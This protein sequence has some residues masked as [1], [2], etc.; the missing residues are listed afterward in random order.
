M[1]NYSKG[2]FLSSIP[3]VTRN[4]LILNVL[5]WGVIELCMFGNDSMQSFSSFLTENL[6][7]HF[8]GS[9]EFQP[10][11]LVTYMFVHDPGS[12][13]HLLFNMFTLWM[14]GR[15]ME[16][17]WGSKRFALFYFVCG[18]GAALVQEVVWQLVWMH[19]YISALAQLNHTSYE[20]I[21]Q[22]INQGLA[23]SDANVLSA[24]SGYKA[25]I[26][27]IGAS[28]AVFG[29]L[30]G[31]AFVFPNIPLY[32]FF[33]PVPIKAKYMVIGYGVIELLLGVSAADSSVAHFAHLGG[34]LFGLILLLYWK[35]KHGSFGGNI[36]R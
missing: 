22:Y 4:I 12:P 6:G 1:N 13:I 17:V 16:H 5:V 30:L 26:L 25:Q 11:Q 29:I 33:I 18:I 32:L 34:M 3:P 35:K 7:L 10:L 27:T 2:N 9:S 15:M 21:S 19:D 14:F 20:T 24:I 23:A 28:G 36:F 31:F 8:W